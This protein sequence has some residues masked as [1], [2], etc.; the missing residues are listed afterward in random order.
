MS[1]K[2]ILS[3]INLFLVGFLLGKHVQEEYYTPKPVHGT[4][5]VDSVLAVSDSIQNG[6]IRTIDS[7]EAVHAGETKRMSDGYDEMLGLTAKYEMA[8]QEMHDS[9]FQA[10]MRFIRV[11]QFKESYNETVHRD[12]ILENKVKKYSAA[13]AF[14]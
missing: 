2:T 10:Y 8:L 12:F 4:V 13:Q 3:I 14:K 11:A 6:Y 7:L 9:N 5:N 1:L